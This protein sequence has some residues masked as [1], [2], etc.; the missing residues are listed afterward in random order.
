MLLPYEWFQKLGPLDER[1]ARHD[2]YLFTL[3]LARHCKFVYVPEPIAEY[4]IHPV[5]V[6]RVASRRE[7]LQDLEGVYA[8]VLTAIAHLPAETQREIKQ[9]WYTK[10][11]RRRVRA[12]ID[13][14]RRFKAISTLVYGIASHPRS[15]GDTWHLAQ[16]ILRT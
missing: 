8:D 5:S 3:G 10:L 15:I 4:R 7:R 13:E 16:L 1:Y 9:H 6:S 14:G 12:E 11:L 2:G